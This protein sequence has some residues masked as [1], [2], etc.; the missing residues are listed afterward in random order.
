MSRN[1]FYPLL[2]LYCIA[3]IYLAWTTPISPHE[4]KLFYAGGGVV[5][6]LMQSGE[7]LFGGFIGIRAWF[8]LIGF[9]SIFLYYRVTWIY[10]AKESDRYL[11]TAVFMLLPG[12]ITALVLSNISILVI[13]L[14]LL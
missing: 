4:A 10:L 6:T 14:V 13:P 5:P 11:A 2:L 1:F 8:L 3:L 7:K 9:F 12:M